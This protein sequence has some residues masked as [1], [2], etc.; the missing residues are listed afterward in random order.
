MVQT[1]YFS[2]L[3]FV[4]V[5][6]D[7]SVPRQV[8]RQRNRANYQIDD[9]KKYWRISLFNVFVDHLAEEISSRVISN[10]DRFCAQM[11][12]PSKIR[13]LNDEHVDSIFTSYSQDMNISKEAFQGEIRRW[14][15]R[16]S[17]DDGRPRPSTLLSLLDNTPKAAYPGIHKALSVL[18]TM[19]AT[20]ASCER[21][22]S[23]MRRIKSYM[24]STMKGERLSDLG[25]LH[26]H[27][28]IDVN[29]DVVI[30]KFASVKCRKID[31]I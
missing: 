3:V 18:L 17:Q 23:S 5:Q 13:N 15:A 25:I 24:R 28:E 30:N 26:I 11:L 20:S 31:F 1:G 21:S 12:M 27:R 14:R 8:A 16:W 22:F 7:A 29:V 9:P 10:H 4:F 19:P 2:Q 6:I